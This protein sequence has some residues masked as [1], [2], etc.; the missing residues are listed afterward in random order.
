MVNFK[1]TIII[2]Y[3]QHWHVTLIQETFEDASGHDLDVVAETA[4]DKVLDLLRQTIRP[5]F[6]NRIDE[7]IMVSS[8]A[9]KGN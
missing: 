4:K 7:V 3:E 6:F 8:I 9:E 2:M 5:E 1:N